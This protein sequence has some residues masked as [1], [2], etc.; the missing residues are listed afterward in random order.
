MTRGYVCFVFLQGTQV[1]FSKPGLS[2]PQMPVTSSEEDISFSSDLH[3]HLHSCAHIHKHL[4]TFTYLKKS[5]KFSCHG[6]RIYSYKR[7]K[8]FH[9]TSQTA[10]S[11]NF[12][13]M[14]YS[15]LGCF[16]YY[17]FSKLFFSILMDRSVTCINT[18]ILLYFH[19]IEKYLY[20]SIGCVIET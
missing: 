4:H 19:F 10:Y 5:Q 6:I 7:R 1:Q 15:Y 17:K 3:E 9:L 14:K 18:S 16:I 13:E 12:L 8:L 20:T 2:S 11:G